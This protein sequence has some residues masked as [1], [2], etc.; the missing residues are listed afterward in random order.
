MSP[1]NGNTP[2]PY[3]FLFILLLVLCHNIHLNPCWFIFF[4]LYSFIT[5][6]QMMLPGVGDWA[7]YWLWRLFAESAGNDASRQKTG[8]DR[9]WDLGDIGSGCDGSRRIWDI[10][11]SQEERE[12]LQYPAA[13]G[14]RCCKISGICDEV[15]CHTQEMILRMDPVCV[16][17]FKPPHHGQSVFHVRPI[18]LSLG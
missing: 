17:L 2:F 10:L 11:K 6:M 12:R 5:H 14:V 8:T 13:Y 3:D 1:F 9:G 15:R 16:C 18:S 4:F 7:D